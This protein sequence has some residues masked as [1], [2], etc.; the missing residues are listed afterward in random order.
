MT[1]THHLD[2]CDMAEAR[3]ETESLGMYGVE[4]RKN[5]TYG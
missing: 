1:S 4:P 5:S 2:C 3:G